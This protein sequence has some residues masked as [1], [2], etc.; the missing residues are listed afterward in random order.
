MSLQEIVC[1]HSPDSDDAFMFYA[2]ATRKVRSRTLSFRHVLEDIE[3]LNKKATQGQYELTAISYHAYPYVAHKYVLM[4]SGSSVGDGYG[5]VV[6]STKS[7]GPD[8]LAGKKIAIPGTMTTAFLALKLFQPDFEHVVCPFDKILEAVKNHEVDAGLI[9]HEG[10]LTYGHGGLHNVID[11]G[12]WFRAKYDLPL[13]LGG[14]ALRRNLA[15]DVQA[16]CSRLM[17]E[18][19]Q[20]SLDHREEA[21]NYALQFARDLDPALADQFVGMYVNHYTVDGGEV[22]PRAAQKLLDLGFEAG[23]IPFKTTVEVVH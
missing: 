17:R 16:E 9:I 21:L 5:P 22:V 4:S 20:Y 7:M 6:V 14:N 8:E 15:P 18:S 11:L 2:L 3:S 1:A 23:L 10:Q 19:I 13:P 12:K